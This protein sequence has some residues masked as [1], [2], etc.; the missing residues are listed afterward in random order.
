MT[1]ISASD[2]PMIFLVRMKQSI[3]YRSMPPG[4]PGGIHKQVAVKSRPCENTTH[5]R[6]VPTMF[7]ISL[8]LLLLD[9]LS[10][11]LEVLCHG[12]GPAL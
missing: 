2:L 6:N 3:P 12:R 9:M 8:N 5:R 11:I 10:V 4:F 1:S 7:M